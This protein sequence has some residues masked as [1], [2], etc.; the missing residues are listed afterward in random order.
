MFPEVVGFAEPSDA[1]GGDADLLVPELE[2]LVVALVDRRPEQLLRDREPV[3]RG[4]ELPRP[5]DRLALE[6]IAER[7]VAEHLEK[8][9]VPRR[10]THALEVGR[11]DALLAGGHPSSRRFL[12]TG[13]IL[14]HRRHARIDE[15]KR[16]IPDGDKGET[17]QAQMPLA[18]EE[19]EVLFAKIVKRGPFHLFVLL[20]SQ[21]GITYFSDYILYFFS[22]VLSRTW[23]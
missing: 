19:R 14:L 5:R 21:T 22:F 6:V 12:L 3:R 16:L 20:R 1:L 10:V 15:Q 13:K 2:R 7:E 11:A 18:L 23:A 9:A 8:G 4:Q 17:R